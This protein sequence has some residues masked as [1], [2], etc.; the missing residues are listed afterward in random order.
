MLDDG[1]SIP[2]S[3]SAYLAPISSSKLY[4]EA[5][6]SKDT[7]DKNREKYLETTYVVHL[8]AFHQLSGQGAGPS[9]TCGRSIQACWEFEHPRKETVVDANGTLCLC[10]DFLV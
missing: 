5:G 8:H 9:G 3:Y 1:I 7:S 2:A 4:N 10:Y 6:G